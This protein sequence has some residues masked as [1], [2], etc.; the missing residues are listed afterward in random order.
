[1]ITES[2][3]SI[4]MKTQSRDNS[5]EEVNRIGGS[6]IVEPQPN[7]RPESNSSSSAISSSR[8]VSSSDAS[9]HPPPNVWKPA[10]A[11]KPSTTS[12]VEHYIP[13]NT[14]GDEERCKR[15]FA[16]ILRAACRYRQHQVRPSEM[17]LVFDGQQN[18][19]IMRL[20]REGK[21]EHHKFD[22]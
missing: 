15:K 20:V 16:K 6:G 10:P 13:P 7:N 1:M 4:G 3:S 2:T 18:I 8:S 5:D 9:F 21:T 19:E 12:P 17:V 14:V 11:T 22:G